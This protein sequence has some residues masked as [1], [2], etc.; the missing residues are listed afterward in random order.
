MNKLSKYL[1]SKF[2][3]P[4]GSI[5]HYTNEKDY[6]EICRCEYLKLNSHRILNKNPKNQEQSGTSRK[7][8]H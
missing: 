2:T 8:S 7:V 6:G 3:R 5:Y 1:G 4:E